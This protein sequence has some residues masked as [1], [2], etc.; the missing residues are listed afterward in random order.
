MTSRE[1][2]PGQWPLIGPLMH[3][4]TIELIFK[5]NLEAICLVEVLSRGAACVFWARLRHADKEAQRGLQLPLQRPHRSAP[6]PGSS[7]G[8]FRCRG[9]GGD[10]RGAGYKSYKAPLRFCTKSRRKHACIQHSR[11]TSRLATPA[12]TSH[13]HGWCVTK[14]PTPTPTKQLYPI[15]TESRHAYT[16]K[17]A[18]GYNAKCAATINPNALFPHGGGA[19]EKGI[20]SSGLSPPLPCSLLD[21]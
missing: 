7:V 13:E 15:F 19:E 9:R 12:R 18:I 10:L 16:H 6:I 8:R 3:G 20:N 4:E 2:H 1:A 21:I 11:A 14:L 5:V 17:K